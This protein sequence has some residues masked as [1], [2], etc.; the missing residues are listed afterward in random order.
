[1]KLPEGFQFSQSSLQ[2]FV[3]CRRRFQ[4]RYLQQLAWPALVAESTPGI[5][6]TA[7]NFEQR[8]YLG[9]RFHH[10]VHQHL[11]GVPLLQLEAMLQAERS[12]GVELLRRWWEAYRNTVAE[13]LQLPD[14]ESRKLP[15]GLY[16]ELSVSAGVGK[17]RL[18]AKFDLVII[19]ADRARIIDWKTGRPPK[20]KRQLSDRLQ[21]RVYRYLL[22]RVAAALWPERDLQPAQIEMIYWFS[23]D[24]T[25]SFHLPYSTA[26]YRADEIYLTSLVQEIQSLEENE[27]PL[28]NRE[29][30]CRFCVYRS[31]CER[32]VRAGTLD[33]EEMAW[34][35]LPQIFE[36]FDQV[37]E[38]AF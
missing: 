26:E 28:T 21:T 33:E 34:E 11:S 3:D 16:P 29:E 24:P 37:G 8:L 13:L 5:D 32:G 38:I 30:R 18:L 14:L 22:Q 1:M 36:S 17:Y 19:D 7:L 12:M 35:E 20:T 6:E 25:R 27:F 31:L 9:E 4:Y 10:L 2:D 23:E 15:D